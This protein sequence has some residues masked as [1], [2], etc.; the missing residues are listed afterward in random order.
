MDL[1]AIKRRVAP[2]WQDDF[3]KFVQGEDD[4]SKDFLDYLDTE[5]EGQK[6]CRAA[7]D[8]AFRIQSKALESVADALHAHS[9]TKR[10]IAGAG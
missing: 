5:G 6:E 1:E 3:V 4:V 8:E 2:E 7:I 9:A 10:N